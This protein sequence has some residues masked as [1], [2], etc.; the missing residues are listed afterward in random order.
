MARFLVGSGEFERDWLVV[1]YDREQ[2][3]G[4]WR[5]VE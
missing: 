4:G 1:L 5:V 2:N 3:Y